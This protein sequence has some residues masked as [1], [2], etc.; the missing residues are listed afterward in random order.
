MTA[1]EELA[2]ALRLLVPGDPDTPTGGF[3]YDKRIAEGLA[4]LG[5]AVQ[6]VALS[7]RFPRPDAAAL[8]G[9]D[10]ALAA[11]APGGTAI[12]DGLALGPS[13]AVV[14]RH[15]QRLRLIGLVHHPLAAE[16]GLTAE[17]ARALATAER[18][19]LATVARVVAT[20]RHT[21]ADLQ[22]DYA[23]PPAHLGVVEPGTD[24][25][26]LARGGGRC[27]CL[28]SVGT[29]TPRKGH[30]V[31]IEAL[32]GLRDLDW[33]LDIIG[34]ATR[35]PAT[36]AAVRAAIA[37]AGLAGRIAL[38]GEVAAPALA[39]AYGRADALV[40]AT[41]FEGFGMVFT[42]A[43]ARGLPIISTAG[44]AVAETVPAD[45]GLL[46]AAG[47]AAGLAAHLQRFLT[48]PACRANLTA[49][50]RRARRH[51]ADWP[52]QARRFAA[53][54]DCTPP[55]AVPAERTG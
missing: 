32:A 2:A 21:A 13:A 15:A 47:D 48:D 34:S 19:A 11:I 16:T 33:R 31:L 46:A 45:A 50:A 42:E 27:P 38:L 12:I 1:S 14:R 55:V 43:L 10:R 7:D 20:S 9:L 23:V 53:E 36:T 24:P 3:L 49:G 39:A 6:I 5:H 25:A 54:I 37:D 4:A 8:D 22:R 30:R 52:T 44:G 29:L 51:L 18:A 28:L 40:S 26:P 35:D 17:E 41:Y